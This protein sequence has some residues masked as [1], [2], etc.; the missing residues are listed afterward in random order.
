MGCSWHLGGR[1]LEAGTP[2]DLVFV[3]PCPVHERRKKNVLDDFEEKPASSVGWKKKM[4]NFNWQNTFSQ[5]GESLSRDFL[6]SFF[7]FQW[8]NKSKS[9]STIV[10]C[11]E[12]LNTDFFVPLLL[13]TQQ[14]PLALYHFDLSNN[15]CTQLPLV[16]LNLEPH[17]VLQ[18]FINGD[19]INHMMEA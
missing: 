15:R 7:L 12:M 3:F 4:L 10:F 8:R 18:V 1:G 16:T 5:A 17:Y 2:S 6:F 19:D 9:V 14:P 11:G 13:W